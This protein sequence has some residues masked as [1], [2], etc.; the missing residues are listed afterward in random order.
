MYVAG[1]EKTKITCISNVRCLS[2]F[3]SS[4]ETPTEVFKP[5][6]DRIATGVEDI[7]KGSISM[8]YPEYFKKWLGVGYDQGPNQLIKFISSQ[9]SCVQL[10]L[11]SNQIESIIKIKFR[12]FQKFFLINIFNFQICNKTANIDTF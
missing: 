7:F 6:L 4:E 8:G 5:I 3:G 2:F 9:T 1:Y 10:S 12:K 11:N